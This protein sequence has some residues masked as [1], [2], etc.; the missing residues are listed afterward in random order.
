MAVD[1]AAAL[2]QLVLHAHYEGEGPMNLEA[3]AEA[4]EHDSEPVGLP[5]HRRADGLL[6]ADWAPLVGLLLDQERSRSNRAAA[7][8]A[9]LVLTLVDQA[10]QLRQTHGEF[11]VGLAG[12]V[13][14]NRYVSEM[15]L[16]ALKEAGFRAYLPIQVPCNDAGLSFGQLIEAAARA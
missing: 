7:F 6:E 5:L 9:S 14:Q 8:Q 13:F 3:L 16:R 10:I 2:L 15:S 11:A 4:S 12:G 1:A